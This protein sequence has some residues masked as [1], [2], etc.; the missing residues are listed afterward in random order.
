LV[1]DNVLAESLWGVV[2]TAM[3]MPFAMLM[4]LF[5]LLRRNST[6]PRETEPVWLP[7]TVI[8]SEQKRH[9]W[10]L[11][12]ALVLIGAFVREL[13]G[14]AAAARPQIPADEALAQTLSDRFDNPPDARLVVAKVSRF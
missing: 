2:T 1:V 5:V 4:G 11:G 8:E 3:T 10:Q 13:S 9:W 6:V 7:Q 14:E 12:A